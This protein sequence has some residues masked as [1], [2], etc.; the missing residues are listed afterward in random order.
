MPKIIKDIIMTIVAIILLGIV[1]V[2]FWQK[3]GHIFEER[4]QSSPN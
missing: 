3:Y 4:Y 2:Q 1:S